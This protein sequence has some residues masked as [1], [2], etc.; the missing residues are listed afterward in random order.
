MVDRLQNTVEINLTRIAHH[1]VQIKLLLLLLLLF[2]NHDY[3]DVT[4]ILLA[5]GKHQENITS[6][7]ET[8]TLNLIYPIKMLSEPDLYETLF[9]IWLK[10]IPK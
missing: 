8:K 9:E 4:L 6:G 5:H 3:T 1:L 2:F 10:Y 7:N